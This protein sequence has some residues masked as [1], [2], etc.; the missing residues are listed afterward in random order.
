MCDPITLGIATLAAT[1]TGV[2]VSALQ[3]DAAARRQNAQIADAKRQAAETKAANDRAINAA[4]QKSPDVGA[5]YKA[6]RLAGSGGI[7]STMLTGAGGA[8]VA[9]SMLGQTSLLGA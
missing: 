8:P 5:L 6:N 4:N 3:G 9:G 2:G 1:A 7:G